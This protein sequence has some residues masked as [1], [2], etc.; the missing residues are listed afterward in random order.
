MSSATREAWQDNLNLDSCA[1][2]MQ[3]RPGRSSIKTYC[4]AQNSPYYKQQINAEYE[5]TGRL[6]DLSP[7][8]CGE[9]LGCKLYTRELLPKKED[10]P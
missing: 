10:M 8:Y 5:T 3:K 4:M 2:C 7:V 1:S 6:D 9:W